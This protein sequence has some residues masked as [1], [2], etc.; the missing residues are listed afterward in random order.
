M[1]Q[2]NFF[3][4]L[5]PSHLLKDTRLSFRVTHAEIYDAENVTFFIERWIDHV[6]AKYTADESKTQKPT[7]DEKINSFISSI[8]LILLQ[9]F[10]LQVFNAAIIISG[11]GSEYVKETRK[12]YGPRHS[13]YEFAI[14]PQNKRS[15]TIGNAEMLSLH[16]SPDLD[17]IGVL[18]LV[19]TTLKV[20]H[21]TSEHN[22]G[23][24][25]ESV[26][27]EL[28]ATKS[29]AKYDW[30]TVVHPFDIVTEVN[31]IIP[32]VIWAINYDHYWDTRLIDVTLSSSEMAVSL[33]PVSNLLAFDI[34]SASSPSSLLLRRLIFIHH[35]H[36][37]RV[38]FILYFYTWMIIAMV[39]PRAMNGY[40]GL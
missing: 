29:V 20:G 34:S 39:T 1:R 23:D 9:S 15:L 13:N 35:R 16:F 18:C 2:I 7:H 26:V 40:S 21:P 36:H 25:S 4:Y 3:V 38:I 8:S 22:N 30:H 5:S 19:G 28:E 32:I 31:G 14:L 24:I 6:K 37:F 27:S 33:S 11:A 10:T 12:K 17:C